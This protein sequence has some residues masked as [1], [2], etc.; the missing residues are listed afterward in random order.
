[1]AGIDVKHVDAD[2]DAV[3]FENQKRRRLVIEQLTQVRELASQASASFGVLPSAPQLFLQP[4]SASLAF[5]GH[6]QHSDQG[7]PFFAWDFDPLAAG[8]EEPERT[9]EAEREL[10]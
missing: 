1:M 4:A 2:A 3:A 8:L 9:H 5:L 7:D 10:R 6:C